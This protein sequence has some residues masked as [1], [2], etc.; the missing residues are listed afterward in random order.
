M[1]KMDIILQIPDV[2]YEPYPSSFMNGWYKRAIEAGIVGTPVCDWTEFLPLTKN[3]TEEL[4]TLGYL[5]KVEYIYLDYTILQIEFYYDTDE[6]L[7]R[8]KEYLTEKTGIVF[9]SVKTDIVE[10]LLLS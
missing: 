9:E 4:V 10:L 1:K 8:A 3:V 2:T 7:A 5:I 6:N